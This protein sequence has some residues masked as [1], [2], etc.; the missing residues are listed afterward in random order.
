MH[1]DRANKFAGVIAGS[2]AVNVNG[3][4]GCQM[5]RTKASSTMRKYLAKPDFF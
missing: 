4:D 5:L 3:L 1:D 2:D